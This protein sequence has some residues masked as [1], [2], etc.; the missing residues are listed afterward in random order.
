MFLKTMNKVILASSNQGKL[1]ELSSY[2]KPLQMELVLQPKEYDVEETG[3]TFI[4][5]A[6]LKARFASKMSGLPSIA[7]DSGLV[8]DILNGEPGVKTARYAGVGAKSAENME[9]LLNQLES[10]PNVEDRHA[11]F[12]CVLVY[13]R[14]HLDPLPVIASGVWSGSIAH[15]KKG[16]NGFGYDPVFYGRGTSQT[17]AEISLEMK[18]Q[19]SHRSMACKNLVK[20]LS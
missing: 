11:Q 9:K 18:A 1:A 13:M 6:I 5:N 19:F 12:V 8:V 16:D 2:L 7:D 3:S 17:A 10:F 4:E 15:E 20:K 14:H